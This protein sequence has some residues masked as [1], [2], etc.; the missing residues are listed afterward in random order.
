METKALRRDAACVLVIVYLTVVLIFCSPDLVQGRNVSKNRIL[1]SDVKVPATKDEVAAEF[2][3]WVASVGADY[4]NKT[5]SRQNSPSRLP[6]LGNKA[7]P[8]IYY[9]DQAGYGNFKTVQEAVNAVP[10]GNSMRVI[11]LVKPGIYR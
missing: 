10:E 3:S 5:S 6:N 11:I 4:K 2:L 9:V 7:E 8:P 1:R